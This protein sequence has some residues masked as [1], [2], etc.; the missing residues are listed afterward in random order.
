M[1]SGGRGTNGTM[2][3]NRRNGR[4]TSRKASSKPRTREQEK[5]ARKRK[6][7]VTRV[8]AEEGL[9]GAPEIRAVRPRARGSVAY[10]K[11]RGDAGKGWV[12]RA[13]WK[14]LGEKRRHLYGEETAG[15]RQEVLAGRRRV[16]A[17]PRL[18]PGDLRKERQKHMCFPHEGRG[19]SR[20][21]ASVWRSSSGK[22]SG[23]WGRGKGGASWTKPGSSGSRSKAP[24]VGE[25]RTRARAKRKAAQEVQHAK[26]DRAE[27]RRLDAEAKARRVASFAVKGREAAV[28]VVRGEERFRDGTSPERVAEGKAR[29]DAGRRRG[30]QVVGWGAVDRYGERVRDEAVRE[31]R[32]EARRA[33]QAGREDVVRAER[34]RAEKVAEDDLPERLRRLTE[35]GIL[36]EG[37]KLLAQW[38]RE[39]ARWHQAEESWRRGREKVEEARQRKAE[40][41]TRRRRPEEKERLEE[42]EV[43]GEE[44]EALKVWAEKVWAEVVA[45]REARASQRGERKKRRVGRKAG[46]QTRCSV[47]RESARLAAQW[48]DRVGFGEARPEREERSGEG[49]RRGVSEQLRGEA[50]FL[51]RRGGR[52]GILEERG[53]RREVRVERWVE[54][55]RTTRTP[56]RPARDKLVCVRVVQLELVSRAA[57]LVGGLTPERKAQGAGFAT[58]VPLEESGSLES[59]EVK[60]LREDLECDWLSFRGTGRRYRREVSRSWKTSREARQHRSADRKEA[61]LRRRVSRGR[62]GLR[63]RLRYRTPERKEARVHRGLAV[64]AEVRKEDY[65]GKL[66]P[67]GRGSRREARKGFVERL[68][69]VR[70]EEARRECSHPWERNPDGRERR[71]VRGRKEVPG[72]RR[73]AYQTREAAGHKLRGQ[74]VSVEVRPLGGD[75][76]ETAREERTHLVGWVRVHPVGRSWVDV[77]LWAVPPQGTPRP[78]W[79]FPG[80]FVVHKPGWTVPG[81]F[82][83]IR[84]R[85]PARK[86]VGR[87]R[88]TGRR[89]RLPWEETRGVGPVPGSKMGVVIPP[90]LR[91]ARVETTAAV[92]DRRS[93]GVVRRKGRSV[94]RE[95]EREEAQRSVPR[96]RLGAWWKG[97]AWGVGRGP[98][99]SE[100]WGGEDKV[101]RTGVWR[102]EASPGHTIPTEGGE[103]AEVEER[104]S[105]EEWLRR[106]R[107]KDRESLARKDQEREKIWEIT[108]AGEK[109]FRGGVGREPTRREERREKLAAWWDERGAHEEGDRREEAWREREKRGR[110]DERLWR[111]AEGRVAEWLRVD[112]QCPR[113]RVRVPLRP[114]R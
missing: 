52:P 96:A 76:R 35:T 105:R 22:W 34:G 46:F 66:L 100:R 10:A 108:E 4:L 74:W 55:R 107:W 80:G 73:S 44:G 103:E 19:A 114:G 111:V 11:R 65:P 20:E 54:G 57:D 112:L 88:T 42:A 14:D 18:G 61:Y 104:R 71:P 58:V 3:P 69:T 13:Y 29:R 40:L 101:A 38:D 109:T 24:L 12:N 47:D 64:R 63:T 6:A 67:R 92:R 25:A 82:G 91:A 75:A 113:R 36:E 102:R 90:S 28:E 15:S 51:D 93:P 39:E 33:W 45:H 1:G 2:T 110:E 106:V 87:R 26:R 83:V 50:G 56:R 85:D 72:W 97:A 95:P 62:L 21:P 68:E 94:S 49:T 17:K 77:N 7:L 8:D 27:R 32:R 43:R 41:R 30:A 5:R 98:P 31:V 84:F 86:R 48:D 89:E 9:P 23:G 59:R 60:V 99:K 78:A 81:A 70:Y 53:S 37:A 79:R 16:S